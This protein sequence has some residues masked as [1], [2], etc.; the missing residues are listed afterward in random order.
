VHEQ[1][2][3]LQSCIV[4]EALVKVQE[5]ILEES[6]DWRAWLN[7]ILEVLFLLDDGWAKGCSLDSLVEERRYGHTNVSIFARLLEIVTTGRI[8]DM[9]ETRFG[10]VGR[11]RDT[12][13]ERPILEE[14]VMKD[15]LDAGSFVYN[16]SFAT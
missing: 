13:W 11:N 3:A 6:R 9:A 1:G 7:S 14:L 15:S 4:S 8:G 16:I 5:N 10:V 12:I 2:A